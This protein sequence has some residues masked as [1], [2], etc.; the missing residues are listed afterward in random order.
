MS[1]EEFLTWAPDEGQAEWVAGKGIAYVST[2]TRHGEMVDFLADLLRRFVAIFALG[3][4]YT[5]QILLRLPT[6]PS[7]RM[8]DIFV[9]SHDAL[10][11]I[12]A[13]WVDGPARFVVEFISDESV[14][15]DLIDKRGEFE[16]AG[17][18]EYLAI[19]SRSGPVAFTFLQRDS[20]GQY[21]LVEPDPDGRYHSR[22]L[23]GF[24]L[25]PRWFEG[26]SL[27]DVEDVLLEIA[28]EA[29]ETWILAK[30]FARRRSLDR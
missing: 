18:P 16:T 1:F 9:V 27:P 19:D 25:D 21:Q 11:R 23:P 28:P 10:D 2:S 17:I 24:W 30:I 5:S 12:Q 6:R 20:N 26:E 7:G 29:Y 15:R 3:R 22:E 14:V 13:Q 4:V 8:P